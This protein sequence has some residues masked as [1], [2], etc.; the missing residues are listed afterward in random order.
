MAVEKVKYGIFTTIDGSIQS[1]CLPVA[2]ELKNNGLEPVLM[3]NM[4]QKFKNQYS[5]EFECVSIPI[6]RGFHPFNLLKVILIL[7]RTFREIKLDA[8]EYGTENAAFCGSISAWLARVPVRIYNHWGARYVGYTGFMRFISKTIEWTAARFS[9][10]VRQVSTKNMEMCVKDHIYPKQK[11]RVLGKGGTVG[12][13]FSKF[14]LELK[15]EYRKQ[16]FE[17]YS[18]PDEAFVFGFVGRIQA[19]KGVTELLTAFRNVLE[20]NSNAYLIMVGPTDEA[21][22]VDKKLINWAKSCNNVIFTGRVSD[23]YRYMSSFDLLVHPTYREGF[24]MVL[25]EAAAL[26]VPIITTNIM[27]PGEFIIN[28]TT[29]TLVPVKDAEALEKEM[30]FSIANYDKELQ[31]AENDF[32]YTKNHFEREIMVNRIIEDRL[33]LLKE[34]GYSN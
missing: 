27:G 4:S 12:V 23:V 31:L 10:A 32:E 20:Y 6:E 24:G 30:K 19:D 1:F 21:N 22:P 34:A 11:V 2:V 7:Y 33:E 25:Q 13:D 28:G 5:K 8:I 29:G 14:N 26:K 18:I 17:K 16:I 15:K 3:C 9:T